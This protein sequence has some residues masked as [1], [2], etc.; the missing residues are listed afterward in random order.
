VLTA[1]STCAGPLVSRSGF[2][3]MLQR[4]NDASG[5]NMSWSKRHHAPFSGLLTLRTISSE[6]RKL[7]FKRHTNFIDFFWKD[8]IKVEHFDKSSP[9]LGT[10][11]P[12]CR[13]SKCHACAEV[14]SNILACCMCRERAIN[15]L[16]YLGNTY[17]AAEVKVDDAVQSQQLDTG[18][19]KESLQYAPRIIRSV[20]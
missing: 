14:S 17:A 12:F 2:F 7:N 10:I 13:H 5:R 4:L 1:L 3:T 11:C 15:R 19:L 9:A 16:T 18:E 20:S 6:V 8:V